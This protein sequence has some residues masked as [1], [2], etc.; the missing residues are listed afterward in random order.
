[1]IL[2]MTETLIVANWKENLD[3]SEVKTWMQEFGKQE[4]KRG[5][6]QENRDPKIEVVICPSFPLI[7]LVSNFQLSS[8]STLQPS[9]FQIGAQNVS[10]F[11]KGAYTGEVSAQ[12]LKSLGVEYVIV[13]HPERREHLGETNEQINQK[14]KLCLKYG[15]KPI[16]CISEL[17]QVKAINEVSHLSLPTSQSPIIA[18]EPLFAVGSGQPDT[19]VNAQKQASAIKK[20]LGEDVWVLY[21]GSADS[22]N[23]SSFLAEKGIQGLLVGAASLDP[24]EF[25][26]I[27][28]YELH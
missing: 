28:N 26:K 27:V 16:V 4:S 7:P 13:G 20:V 15:L 17:D 24:V 10:E 14:I 12:Q 2:F 9:I 22:R 5:S 6:V 11:E 23:A 25:A 3:A 21:G 18:Y 19:P 8:S 1:M